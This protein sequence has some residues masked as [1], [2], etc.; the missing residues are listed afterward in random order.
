MRW[1]TWF[2]QTRVATVAF[3]TKGMCVEQYQSV[4][5]IFVGPYTA[6]CMGHEAPASDEP[7]FCCGI[8]SVPNQKLIVAA[9]HGLL[10]RSAA[11]MV[12]GIGPLRG[13]LCG[14]QQPFPL[15]NKVH[16]RSPETRSRFSCFLINSWTQPVV[17]VAEKGFVC[18]FFRL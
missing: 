18:W 12:A 11:I 17:V 7:V 4:G 6:C 3:L 16:Q 1:F 5:S 9:V 15:V 2:D 13:M 8:Y 14:P 10:S